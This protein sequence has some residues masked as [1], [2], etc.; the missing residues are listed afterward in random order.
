MAALCSSS[1]SFLT[2]PG[3][4]CRRGIRCVA[5][6]RPSLGAPIPGKKGL[7]ETFVEVSADKITS[8]VLAYW[9]HLSV[10]SQVAAAS[11]GLSAHTTTR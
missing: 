6:V 1:G 5:A 8:H 10:T 7:A 9:P 3:S 11:P 4:S 2:T